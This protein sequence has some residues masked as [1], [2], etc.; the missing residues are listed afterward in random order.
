MKTALLALGCT[1]LPTLGFADAFAIQILSTQY[2]TELSVNPYLLADLVGSQS[3][4]STTPIQD[5]IDIHGNT[6]AFAHADLFAIEA[7]TDG[8]WLTPDTQLGQATAVAESMVQFAPLTDGVATLRLDF[9]NL[10]ALSFTE[11][12]IELLDVTAEAVLWRYAW[13]RLLHFGNVPWPPPGAID[14]ASGTT[15]VLAES[16][17]D[18]THQYALTMHTGTEAS[19]DSE[20]IVLQVSGLE[21]VPEPATLL[22]VTSGLVGAGIRRWRQRR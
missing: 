3:I 8:A 16:L 5:A 6:W 11:G 9:T 19:T 20:H 2:R 7:L 10:D 15:V 14:S 18:M 21:P 1:L 4:S 22:L 17:F 13:E 12:F